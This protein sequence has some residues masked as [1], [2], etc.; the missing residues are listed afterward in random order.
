MLHAFHITPPE[1]REERRDDRWR[2][3]IPRDP[4]CQERLARLHCPAHR[5][6]VRAGPS[7]PSD[8]IPHGLSSSGGGAA[9]SGQSAFPSCGGELSPEFPALHLFGPVATGVDDGLPVR[10]PPP[11][12]RL[13]GIILSRR[14]AGCRS[15]ATHRSDKV[16]ETLPQ[17]PLA[18]HVGLWGSDET[19]QRFDS[20]LSWPRRASLHFYETKQS[21]YVTG[22]YTRLPV[23][24]MYEPSGILTMG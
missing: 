11:V 5:R 7:P 17:I 24:V 16:I 1:S 19:S 14:S 4:P 10:P 20:V 8:L 15:G 13:P 12:S 22:H 18:R 23:S 2:E 6:G 21:P 9:P 3:R